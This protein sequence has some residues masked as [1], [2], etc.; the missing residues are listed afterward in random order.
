MKICSARDVLSHSDGQTERHDEGNSRFSQ[1][2]ENR[3]QIDIALSKSQVSFTDSTGWTFYRVSK[4]GA[5]DL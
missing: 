2:C 5:L 4:H 1:L 3:P